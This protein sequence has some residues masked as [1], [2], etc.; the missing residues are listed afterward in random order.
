MHTKLSS[1]LALNLESSF[2]FPKPTNAES[3]DMISMIMICWATEFGWFNAPGSTGDW[4]IQI[5]Y[6]RQAYNVSVANTYHFLLMSLVYLGNM[7]AAG[8]V[9]GESIAH[10]QRKLKRLSRNWD[11]GSVIITLGFLLSIRC[12]VPRFVM[13]FPYR[14]GIEIHS[15]EMLGDFQYSATVISKHCLGPVGRRCALFPLWA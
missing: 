11:I 14:Q 15:L 12:T 2:A 13:F 10:E 6:K 1:F 7:N 8:G 9:A 4:G 5:K 3:L